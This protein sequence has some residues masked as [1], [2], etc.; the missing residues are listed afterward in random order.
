[1]PTPR[2]G[3]G[4]GGGGVL[5][6]RR[7]GVK[8][9]ASSTLPAQPPLG[10]ARGGRWRPQRGGWPGPGPRPRRPSSARTCGSGSPPPPPRCGAPTRSAS[11]RAG[12]RAAGRGS[13]A[14]RRETLAAQTPQTHP[15]SWRHSWRRSRS[16][17]HCRRNCL[18]CLLRRRRWWTSPT[19]ACPCRSCRRPR[20]SPRLL[21]RSGLRAWR[22]RQACARKAGSRAVPQQPNPAPG[23][24]ARRHSAVRHRHDRKTQM[25][26]GGEARRGG[27]PNRGRGRTR[28]RRG[29]E[30]TRA[31]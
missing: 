2:R 24:Q 31:D 12:A 25:R 15:P 27:C 28:A 10:R 9:P 1:M 8:R 14:P 26:C 4:G 17:S 7:R 16:P 6:R 18:R 29:P 5:S 30:C 3:G 19:V 23:R 20:R 11:A 13:T 22:P 21:K